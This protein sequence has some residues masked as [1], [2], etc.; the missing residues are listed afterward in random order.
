ME[1]M[2]EHFLLDHPKLRKKAAAYD[3]E[4][5]EEAPQ[6]K[7]HDPDFDEA[8]N[9]LDDPQQNESSD[10]DIVGEKPPDVV[11]E[12]EILPPSEK[13]SSDINDWEEV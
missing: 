4:Y 8:W 5:D 9:A 6:E 12:D 3:P 2:Y 10:K 13:H 11:S 7:Y 1:L